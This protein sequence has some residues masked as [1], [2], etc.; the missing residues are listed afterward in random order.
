LRLLLLLAKAEILKTSSELL[1]WKPSILTKCSWFLAC[2]P[3][4]FLCLLRHR[5]IADIHRR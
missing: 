3:K 5:Q 2:K 4:A 1:L